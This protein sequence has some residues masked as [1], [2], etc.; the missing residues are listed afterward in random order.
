MALEALFSTGDT[1]GKKALVPRIG[2][3]LGE[4]TLVYPS[5]K[6]SYSVGGTIGDICELRNAFAHGDVVPAKFLSTPPELEVKSENVR[7]YADVLRE[8]SAVIL[9]L[10]L[11]KIFGEGLVETFSDKAKMEKLF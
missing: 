3:F 9:R 10:C 5:E 2:E 1:Y 7:S 11:L 6:A 4:K 8:A